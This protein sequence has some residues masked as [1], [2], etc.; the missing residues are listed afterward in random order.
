MPLAVLFW[1]SVLTSLFVLTSFALLVW[2]FAPVTDW[3]YLF[4]LNF[5][6]IGLA[7]LLVFLYHTFDMLR[8]KT[9]AEG[10]RI[11][12]SYSYAYATSLIATFGATITPAHVGGELIIFYMLK[13]LGARNS[14]IWGTIL[15]KT[16]SGMSF[17][18]L[19]LPFFVYYLFKNP[20][21]LKKL[22]I[23][24]IIFLFFSLISYPVWKFFQKYKPQNSKHRKFLK[25]LKL[26]CLTVV[27]F[28]KKQKVLFLKACFY[29]ILLYLTF[30]SFAPVLLKAFNVK[31]PLW[32]IYM[33]E[34]PLVYAIFTSPSPGG[35]GIGE[36]GAA[37]L[38]ADL[39]P[40]KVIG[41]FVILWR[42]FSQYF[43]AIV[44]GILFTYFV[45][46]DWKS[47]KGV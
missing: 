4:H 10:Y 35:S 41:L 30:L 47:Q 22:T 43:S 14:K 17:F 16:V 32:K 2:K 31:L 13:R 19:A 7:L 1:G 18:I 37:A 38:F 33:I 44:G 5:N 27:Y 3:G 15:F 24:G 46:K 34:L 12:Y 45:L 21:V 20:A 6:Y 39:I 42:F 36:L 29:S 26:Y 25:T 9:I 40:D 11:K 23:L 28:W 8:L